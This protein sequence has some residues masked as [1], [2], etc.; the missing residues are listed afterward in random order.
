MRVKYSKPQQHREAFMVKAVGE[1]ICNAANSRAAK[2]ESRRPAKQPPTKQQCKSA[3]D[4]LYKEK[5]MRNQLIII[6]RKPYQIQG[7]RQISP[8]TSSANATLL[9]MF[10]SWAWHHKLLHLKYWLHILTDV[11]GGFI[12]WINP[13]FL[14]WTNWSFSNATSITPWS[15]LPLWIST[16]GMIG[17]EGKGVT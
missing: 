4:G 12:E 9:V 7:I 8:C 6:I 10:P 13:I 1:S 5:R 16:V 15:S 17:R 3:D 2:L 14:L 11:L